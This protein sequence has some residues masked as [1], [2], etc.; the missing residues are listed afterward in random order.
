[1]NVPLK[2]DILNKKTKVDIKE[3]DKK[4]DVLFKKTN[5]VK[6]SI[7][8]QKHKEFYDLSLSYYNKG[9]FVSADKNLKK[10]KEFKN[11]FELYKL[12]DVMYHILLIDEEKSG[13]ILELMMFKS[14]ENFEAFKIATESNL[15]LYSMAQKFSKMVKYSENGYEP[16]MYNSLFN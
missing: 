4:A 8:D 9:D 12:N 13:E 7:N 14:E 3:K 1:M 10:A 16:K 15:E 2:N 6:P 11:T 5:P